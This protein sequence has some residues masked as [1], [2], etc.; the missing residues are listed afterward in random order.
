MYETRRPLAISDTHSYAGW[1]DFP[2]AH[3]ERSYAGAPI[4]VKGQVIGFLNLGSAKAGFFTEDHA[5]RLQA[6]ANQAAI[7]LENARLFKDLEAHAQR[8]D[9][10]NE[11]T[12]VALSAPNLQ[13]MLQKLAA[14]LAR[15]FSAEGVY[16]S[17]WDEACSTTC[18]L[19]FLGSQAR[20]A[21][22]PSKMGSSTSASMRWRPGKFWLPKM[23]SILLI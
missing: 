14:R 9:M 4:C 1:I 3:W 8:M 11:L 10:L 15:L 19:P 23:L 20:L 18:W 12:Q 16:I 2:E 7:A 5:R 17:L 6:F 21:H 22:H 13:N